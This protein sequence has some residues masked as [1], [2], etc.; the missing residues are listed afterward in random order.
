MGVG[1]EEREKVYK[2]LAHFHMEV[3]KSQALQ[4][5]TWRPRR[6]NDVNSSPKAD[7]LQ[8]QEELTS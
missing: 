4:L 2:D 6:A 1:E 3:D 5:E 7:S 8:T